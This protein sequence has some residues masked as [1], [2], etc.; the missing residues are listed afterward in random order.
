MTFGTGKCK[1]NSIIKGK[2]NETEPYNLEQG[3]NIDRME[4]KDTYKYLGYLQNT[5]INH[6]EIK[7][8]TH[9]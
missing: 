6:T 1:I 4:A 7:K 9:D 3:G 8:N 5:C 2:H